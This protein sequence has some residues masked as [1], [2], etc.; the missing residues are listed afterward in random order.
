MKKQK[1]RYL[2]KKLIERTQELTNKLYKDSLYD[3]SGIDSQKNEDVSS[4]IKRI[5]EHK[6]GFKIDRDDVKYVESLRVKVDDLYL[7]KMIALTTKELEDI[8]FLHSRKSP[9]RAERTIDAINS[10]LARRF[11]VDDDVSRPKTRKKK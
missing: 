9:R 7:Q 8:L 11:I 10:E 2:T 6:L 1:K 3:I 4:I 5:N